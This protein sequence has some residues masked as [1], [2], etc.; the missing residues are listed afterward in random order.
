[1]LGHQIVELLVLF[2]ARDGDEVE[3]TRYGV[4]LGNPVDRQQIVG[5]RS[6]SR[7]FD[8]HQ[9]ESGD[10]GGSLRWAGTATPR[11]ANDSSVEAFARAAEAV[12]ARPGKLEKVALIAEYLRELDAADLVAAARFFTGSAFAAR[13]HRTLSV[14]GST[15]VSAA[16]RVWVFDDAR[17]GAAYRETGDLGAALGRLVRPPRDATL[18]TDRLTPASLDAFFGEIADA[19]GKN[20]G[21]RREAVLERIFRAC[22][23][24][25]VATYVVKIV[26]GELRIGLREGLVLDAIARA[27]DA[28]PAA[29]RRGLMAAGDV[30]EV[31][32]AAKQ[33]TLGELR[34]LYGTPIGFMLASPLAYGETYKELAGATWLVEDKYD[35]VRAQAHV[36]D[37]TVRLFSRRLN[38]V[39]D[40][41]P[42]IATALSGIERNAVFDGEI[43]GMRDGR[44]LPFRE[45]QTRMQAEVPLAYVV[46]DVL[47]LGDDLLVDEPL[48]RRR[49][50]LAEAVVPSG[51]LLLA[52]FDPVEEVVALEVND[53][54]EG[55][56]KRGNEGLMLKRADSPYAPGRRGKWWLKL[57][58]E[59][60]TLDVAVIAVE[61]G[62]GKRSNVLSD[63][64]F[65]VRGD[66]G[67]LVA[68]GKA[69]SG[70]TDAEI[71]ELTQW[72]L[73]H[74]LP[75]DRQRE[76]ARA[77][78]I[79][80]EPL[81]V[82]EVAFD[83]VQKSDLH[84]SGFALRFPRILAIRNDKPPEEIDTLDAV[85]EIYR[86]MLA[87][88]G[89]S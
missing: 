21:K 17:L 54:F 51:T 15:I 34:V 81:I 24:P 52:R 32:L 35:G 1:M 37:G 28:D 62:H 13:D 22:D 79:P 39:T 66:D 45:L 30:G 55:A 59:L 4:D 48:V 41:Y 11:R 38:D 5:D 70:L 20:A 67:T 82:I 26:T 2:H 3:R 77:Y 72:F 89:S 68:I 16:R 8:I 23:D 19:S 29:V 78:E 80:V 58:R 43:V 12:A 6:Q 64:T 10:H 18:F 73:A 42:Q 61:W 87:R 75:P 36:Y 33:G 25:L 85:R 9:N 49:E 50:L 76:K 46:F 71:A 40:S 86:E 84:E 63:Y 83:A 57:K 47:A 74:R 27:F 60:T 88:E 7:T 56:R 44:V 14:G 53:R 31:A 69:Y 65:A